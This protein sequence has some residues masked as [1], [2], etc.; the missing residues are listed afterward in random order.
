MIFLKTLFANLPILSIKS[1][2]VINL[3]RISFSDC[4]I[5]VS[6]VEG[7]LYCQYLWHYICLHLCIRNKVSPIHALLWMVN[8]IPNCSKRITYIKRISSFLLT[9]D[10]FLN[11][12]NVIYT[13][14]FPRPSYHDARVE[15][16][17]SIS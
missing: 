9:V 15:M 17:A 2:L 13:S 5:N 4:E 3:F 8:G 6:F 11:Y 12:P 16:W 7:R 14:T 10:H 1:N